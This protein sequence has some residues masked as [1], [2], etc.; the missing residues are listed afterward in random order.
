ML[1]FPK[2]NSLKKRIVLPKQIDLAIELN[3]FKT[4]I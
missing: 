4:G 1:L 3:C 2:V